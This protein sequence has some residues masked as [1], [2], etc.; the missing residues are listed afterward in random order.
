MI[1]LIRFV[2]AVLASLFKSKS[3]LEA[4]NAALRQQLI[5]LR[6]KVKGGAKLTNATL[7]LCPPLPMVPVDHAHRRD[8][9]SGD[10][11]ALASSQLPSLLELEIAAAPLE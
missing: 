5:I 11:A 2:L 6:R 7:V 8:H 1:G 10:F 4:E 9:P 3:R